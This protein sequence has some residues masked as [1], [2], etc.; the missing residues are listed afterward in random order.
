MSTKIVAK[1]SA[2][3]DLDRT[4]DCCGDHC[5]SLEMHPEKYGLF[6]ASLEAMGATA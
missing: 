2:G 6:V 1:E 5:P 4:H 3:N